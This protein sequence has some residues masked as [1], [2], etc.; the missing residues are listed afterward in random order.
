MS[1]DS[2]P[3]Q[4]EAGRP[5]GLKE[6]YSVESPDD[7]RALYAKWADTYESEFTV[8]RRYLYDRNAAELLC[9]GFSGSGPVLDVGCGTG[10]VGEQLRRLGIAVVDGLD[11]SPEMLSKARSKAA[12]DGSPVYRQL[13]EADLTGPIDIASDTYAGD[14]Q[15]RH[16]HARPCRTRRHRRTPAGSPPRSPLR[17]RRQLLDL[18]NQRLQGS[19]RALRRGRRPSKAWMCSCARCTRAPTAASPITWPRWPSS[20]S[21]DR[22]LAALCGPAS[23]SER[24]GA[25][26]PSWWALI[27]GRRHKALSEAVARAARERS[28]QERATQHRTAAPTQPTLARSR[29]RGSRRPRRRRRPERRRR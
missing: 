19:F 13:I 3:S 27:T 17:D 29:R 4:T 24:R 16:V 2:D 21:P 11:L 25:Q 22:P 10:L 8:P 23:L 1:G 18:R 26:R 20:P 28:E 6:A 9:Q 15:R 14:R 12:A 7:N 5:I